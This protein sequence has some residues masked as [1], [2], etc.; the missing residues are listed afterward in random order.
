MHA[1]QARVEM[2]HV[3]PVTFSHRHV[4]PTVAWPRHAREALEKVEEETLSA[5]LFEKIEGRLLLVVV[6][7][8]GLKRT[9]SEEDTKS[10]TARQTPV[11]LL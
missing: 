2:V 6:L 9:S 5:S 4:H 1:H 11:H 7:H 10:F 3:H 8:L